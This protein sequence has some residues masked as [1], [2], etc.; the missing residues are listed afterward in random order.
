MLIPIFTEFTCHQIRRGRRPRN[1]KKATCHDR[2]RRPRAQPVHFRGP[3]GAQVLN[4]TRL[5]KKK[6]ARGRFRGSAPKICNFRR[7]PLAH[8]PACAWGASSMAEELPGR[9]A[10]WPRSSLAVEPPSRGAG[11]R[12]RRVAGEPRQFIYIYIHLYRKREREGFVV[13]IHAQIY[14]EI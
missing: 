1:L 11:W 8:P 5:A 10:P 14:S 2:L 9:G 13:Y 7:A 4:F 12:G 6:F 3:W